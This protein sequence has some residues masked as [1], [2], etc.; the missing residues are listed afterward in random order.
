MFAR[1]ALREGCEQRSCSAAERVGLKVQ[2]WHALLSDDL[3]R[4]WDTDAT[5]R[6]QRDGWQ[7]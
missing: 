1:L 3:G 5:K 4:T 7:R 6:D 2:P